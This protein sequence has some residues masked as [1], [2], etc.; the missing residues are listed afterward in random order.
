MEFFFSD[1][2]EKPL[3]PEEVRIRELIAKPKMHGQQVFVTLDI[4]PFQERP[5]AEIIITN[6]DGIAVAS[7]NIIETMFN[8]VEMNLHLRVKPSAGKYSVTAKLFF[9]KFEKI[10]DTENQLRPLDPLFV[11]QKT[12][13]FELTDELLE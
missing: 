9:L 8:K 4:S 10:P 3:P 6:Q 5:N 11:D 2:N 1:P 12:T 7:A 13:I